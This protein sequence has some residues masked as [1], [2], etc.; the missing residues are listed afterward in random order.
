MLAINVSPHSA[1]FIRYYFSPA[2]RAAAALFTKLHRACVELL[3]GELSAGPLDEEE[4]LSGELIW[5][6]RLMLPDDVDPRE[7]HEL[8][9]YEWVEV[10]QPLLD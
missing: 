10:R 4:T 3:G 8:R 1:P 7:V 5:G 6:L 2:P 9:E